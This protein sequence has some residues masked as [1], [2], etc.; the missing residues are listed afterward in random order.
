MRRPT[1]LALAFILLG[2]LASAA[3]ATAQPAEKSAAGDAE[4]R[5]IFPYPVHERTL[6]N[7]LEVVVIPFD[8]PGTVAYLS[9]VRTG[10]REEVEEGHS[11]FAHFFEHMMFRGTERYPRDAYNDELRRMGADSNAFTTDDYTNYY[12]IGPASALPRMMDI[13][14]DRFQNLEYSED[15]FRTEALAVLGEYN[16]SASSPWMAMY[17][18]MRDLAFDE[19][20]YEHTTLGFLADIEAMPGY[21]DYSLSFFDRFYRPENTIVLIVGDV[22]PDE[23]LAMAEEHYGGWEA[24]YQPAAIAAE[25]PQKEARKA[26]IDWDNPTRPFLMMGY[27]TPAFDADSV[28]YAALDLIAQLLFSDASPLYQEVVVDRQI[29]DQ[30]SGGMPDHRDPYLFSITARAKSEEA[31]AQVESAIQEHI[32]KLQAEPVDD[33]R[34]ERIKSH[35]RYGFALGMDSAASVAFNAAHALQLTGDVDAINRRYETYEKVTPKDIQMAA[36]K[37]FQPERR[38]LVTLSHGTASN[39]DDETTSGMPVPGSDI[40]AVALPSET[41]IV[42]LRLMFDAGSMD[43]PEGK[44]GLALLTARMLAEASTAERSYGELVEALY[45]MAAGID[46]LAGREVTTIGGQVHRDTLGDYT[47]LLLEAVGEPGFKQADLERHKGELEAYLTT[48][49]RSSND[50]LL[51]LEAMQQEIYQGHP[52]GHAPQGTVAGLASISLDDV[53][54]FYRRHYTLG[55]LLL[56]IAGGYPEGYEAELSRRLAGKLPPGKKA[57][58]GLTDGTL[59]APAGVEGR[60]FTLIDKG[61]ASVGIHLGYPL[62]FN[63]ADDEYYPMMVANSY[64]GEHRTSHGRLMQQLRGERGLNYGDYSYIEHW[65]QRPFTSTPTPG[66][67]R[68]QQAFTVWIRPVRPETAHF[69]LRNALYEVE[70]LRDRGLTEAEFDLTRDFLVNYSKL[71]AQTLDERLG[72]HMDS[73]FYGMPYYIDEIE[74][75]LGGLTVEDVNRA[76]K[77]HVRTDAYRAVLVTDEAEAMTATLKAGEPSPM[78][79]N[80]Q[81]SDEVKKADA[82]IVDLEVAPTAFEIVPVE[83][84]FAGAPPAGESAGGGEAAAGDDG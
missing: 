30:L 56:G 84:M 11:G 29:A 58:A 8:S 14:A 7:G 3:S 12:I 83:E 77:K 40:Q 79:Y 61:T 28:E 16:K 64:L 35:L 1:I 13:E 49:L 51:G 17:E 26:H 23:T 6:D 47:D 57:E 48:T 24:G 68:R 82:K 31:L 71:W 39:A 18:T 65:H 43:D 54:A 50:E 36:K 67:P 45:P 59:P 21:F 62:P 72:F 20:T 34:L 38:T 41:P 74:R 4:A 10:S 60:P 73:R 22:D 70:R 78:T 69:A 19:H 32:A 27:R 52:Y 37:Y 81:V 76:I 33:Q 2:S 63:R 46:L 53:K 5:E 80:S 25:P 42:A 75:R 44:E 55:N 15:A 66:V 9:V